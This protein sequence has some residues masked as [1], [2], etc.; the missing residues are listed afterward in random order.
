[1]GS[2]VNQDGR[3]SS[4]T[5]PNGPSQTGVISAALQDGSARAADVTGLQM[6]GTGTALGDP[7]EVSAL[8]AV[9][10]AER[11][12]PG[13][14]ALGAVKSNSGHAEAAAGTAGL[15]QA[16]SCVAQL[17]TAVLPHV[18]TL[19]RSWAARWPTAARAWT[20]APRRWC[21]AAGPAGAGGHGRGHGRSS[22]AYRAPTR[23]RSWAGVRRG[24]CGEAVHGRVGAQPVLVHL[25]R[26]SR[27]VWRAGARRRGRRCWRCGW[28]AL[29]ARPCTSGRCVQAG[30]GAGRPGRGGRE[31]GGA[32]GGVGARVCA[33]GGYFGTGSGERGYCC[34]AGGRAAESGDVSVGRGARG[35]AVRCATS[36]A[37]AAAAAGVR[38]RA[39]RW[40]R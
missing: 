24:V 17:G 4:L 30:G 32:G 2:A 14:V 31:R 34:D 25:R 7:I 35:R 37:G 27:L 29:R 20:G 19:N 10:L 9:V 11:G 22:F 12:R 33:G 26:P 38:R 8:A 18:R 5:A 13:A 21:A 36:C 16:A 40:P 15:L 28:A 1:M 23:T 3:S 6:H 39:G